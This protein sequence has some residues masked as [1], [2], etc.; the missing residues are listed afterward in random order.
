MPAYLEIRILG[1]EVA[2]AG[3]RPCQLADGGTT[4]AETSGS[5][6]VS[7]GPGVII[8]KQPFVKTKYH[9][10]YISLAERNSGTIQNLPISS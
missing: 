3:S 4:H 1:K 2:G 6:R 10:G 5:V 9:T 7:C 8:L